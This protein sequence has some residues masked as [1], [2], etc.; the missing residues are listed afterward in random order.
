MASEPS[1]QIRVLQLEQLGERGAPPGVERGGVPRCPA[2]QEKV[3]LEEAALPCA[4]EE[5]VEVRLGVNGG[6]AEVEV[7]VVAF[8]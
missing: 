4:V 8:F 2:S 3:E 6:V 1:K 5:R 7:E